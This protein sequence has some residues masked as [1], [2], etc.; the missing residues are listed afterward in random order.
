MKRF[1]VYLLAILFTFQAL[2]FSSTKSN[3]RRTELC[4]CYCQAAQTQTARISSS[5][6]VCS[7]DDLLKL[8]PVSREPIMLMSSRPLLSLE[9]C[10]VLS[11]YLLHCNNNNI[12][13]GTAS[14]TE[15][16]SS[17]N[18]QNEYTG[19]QLL[20]RLQDQLDSLT[21]FSTH[22]GDQ[23]RYVVYDPTDDNVA[24]PQEELLLLPDGLHVDT[25]NGKYFRQMTILVYLSTNDCGA[26]TFPLARSLPSSSRSAT[27]EEAAAQELIRSGITHTRNTEQGLSCQKCSRILDQ[28]AVSLIQQ[29]QQQG[30]AIR[31]NANKVG[32]RVLPVAGQACVFYGLLNKF[33][34]PLSFHGG[35]ALVGGT[36][37]EKRLLTFF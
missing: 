21:G 32:I 5:S 33:A 13:A 6:S 7:D 11:N 35:E 25:N 3:N 19:K 27:E 9:E 22:E 16:S 28:A 23:I 26:T 34:D 20:Q 17:G 14:T 31:S 29:Q 37:K 24:T 18:N 15:A 4:R 2:A 8:I 30:T 36:R 1:L 12:T 10:D